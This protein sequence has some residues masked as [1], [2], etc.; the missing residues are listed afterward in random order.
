[1]NRYLYVAAVHIHGAP[2]RLRHAF[3]EAEA[4]DEARL[5]GRRLLERVAGVHRVVDALIVL[6]EGATT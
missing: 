6:D 2:L 3:V 5:T 4:E 1:M